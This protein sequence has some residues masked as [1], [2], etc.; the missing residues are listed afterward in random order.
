MA[1][2]YTVKKGDTLWAIAKKYL[3]SGSKY[4]QLAKWNNISN[5]NLIYVGQVIKLNKSSSSSSGSSSSSSSS[6]SSNSNKVTITAFGLQSNA[7]DVLFVTWKWS[8]S[9]TNSY[10]VEWTYD[11][12]D[13]VWFIGS[14][15]TNSVDSNNAAASR[16]S[17]Y[18]I[19]S[20]AKKVRVRIKPI[21]KTYTKNN[22]ETK[23]WTASWSSYKTYT[24]STP[25]TTPSAPTVKIEKYQL[26]ATL[27]NIDISGATG[28]QF[29]IYKNDGSSAFKSGKATI[30]AT[31]SASYS[32][33]VD[34]GGEYKV[35]CR[36]YK[37]STYSDWSTF[38]SGATTIPAASS[39]ITTIRANSSTS[40]YL[41]WSAVTSAKTYDIEYTTK[42]DYFDNS[43]QT[44][45]KTG[46]EFTHFEVTGLTSGDEYFFR[47]RAVNDAGE[48]SWSEVKSVTIG[49]KPSAPTTW[50]STTTCMSGEDLKL[51]WVHNAADGSSQTYAEIEL[52]VDGVTTTKTIKTESTS[53]EDDEKETDEIQ[54]YTIDTTSYIEGTQIKWRVRTAGITK[55]Y[56]DWS[57]QRTVDI[58][59]SPTLDF[60][61]TNVDGD[62]VEIVEV[63][64]FYIYGLPGPNTQAPIGYHLSITANESYQTVDAVGNEKNVNEG[65]EV[66][67]KYFD[68]TDALLVEMS[69]GNIDLENNI[70]YTATC[71]VSM[72][73]GLTATE[74]KEFS[75]AWTDD[76]YTP[77]AEIGYDEE[78]Y[79]T[80]VRPYCMDHKTIYYQV[81]RG[82]SPAY[83]L[84]TT[85]LDE[86]IIENVY[87]T[88]DEIVLIGKDSNDAELYYCAVYVDS[89]GEPIETTY[90]NVE[91]SSDAYEKTSTVVDI[92]SIL[93]VQTTTGENVQIGTNSDG[94][95]LYYSIVEETEYVE[96]VTLSVYRREF[97]GSFTELATGLNNTSNTYVT[98]P[99]PALDYARYRIVAITNSTGAVSYYDVPGYPIGEPA[100]I[101]QWD[102]QWTTFD[103]TNTDELAQPP[104][105]GS[106]LR[107]P[108]NVDVS[109]SNGLD[110]A[111]VEYIGRKRPVSYYGTQLGEKS[112]WNTDIPAEDKETLYALRRLAIWTG[113]VYVREPSGS[114]Y[115]AN[116]SVSFS[117]KHKEVTIPVTF[118]ITRVEGGV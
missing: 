90:Y 1:S 36:A 4:Q 98:D 108:Y 40:V 37:G 92:S 79:V 64:P 5:P 23:Y 68:I 12:G 24:D 82:S 6:T 86:T 65:E 47:V 106:L 93:N 17:T 74:S 38:S 111:L 102:E 76:I 51:Y 66:Y 22:K 85:E 96:D 48:S 3:G 31:K 114:G 72:N 84:T 13:G 2:T 63:F 57:I 39:G 73:S 75:V 100:I 117:K 25:L 107:L 56:G 28:I 53:D 94:D 8:K 10:M 110:V 52:I 7:D 33:K 118:S 54:S 14:N 95:K 30:T 19:P 60:R 83:T 115:W 15:T 42:T 103:T 34:A 21:S 50:A 67:S 113:D 109:D 89:D 45:T 112:T 58:Y 71:V 18:S 49:K 116:I 80:H 9:N 69:A 16:Q 62:D 104:W 59:A 41:E 29:Q 105:T 26:T 27:E 101:I 88:T 78:T 70:K 91:Y 99:H 77:N 61:I 44:T 97:D 46:I 32:C 11:T 55:E 35:R 20:N 87:T 43:D 81:D